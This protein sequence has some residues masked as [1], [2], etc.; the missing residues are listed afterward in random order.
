MWTLPDD[1]IWE[2]RE[3]HGLI[4]REE[5]KNL[6]EFVLTNGSASRRRPR[7][8]GLWESV[9]KVIKCIGYSI[10]YNIVTCD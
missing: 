9:K 2:G 3:F 1:T 8:E 4:T 10:I 5:K 7:E 6:C